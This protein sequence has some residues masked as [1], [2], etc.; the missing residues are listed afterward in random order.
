M[1]RVAFFGRY[2]RGGRVYADRSLF[3]TY[4]SPDRRLTDGSKSIS[5][6]GPKRAKYRQAV[7]ALN[8]TGFWA[9]GEDTNINDARS[10][11][12]ARL[13]CCGRRFENF[14]G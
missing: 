6:I 4:I 13:R 8:L 12:P 3:S 7:T 14:T 10:S 1:S 9:Q 5:S 11:V 2:S